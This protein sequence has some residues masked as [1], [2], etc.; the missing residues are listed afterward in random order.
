MQGFSSKV[1]KSIP[2]YSNK[3]LLNNF[4]HFKTIKSEF[5]Y[6]LTRGVGIVVIENLINYDVVKST[7]QEIYKII[8]NQKETNN[9][10][11]SNNQR[12]W[13]FYEKFCISNTNLFI[14]YFKN[15]IIDLI[16]SSYLGPKYEITNQINIVNPGS[17]AQVFHR[18]YHLGLMD[19]KMLEEYPMNVHISSPNLTLQGLVAHSKIN[20]KN[21]STKFIPYSHLKKNGF[22]LIK[23]NKVLD[24]CENNYIQL[25]LNIGDGVF[26]NPAIF[27][28]AGDNNDNNDRIAN[29]FQI[30]SAFSKP[31]ELVNNLLVKNLVEDKLNSMKLSD[32]ELKTLKNI[33]FNKY[34]YP[35]NLD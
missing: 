31:M 24:I 9:D 18:D 3:S 28:A 13:N 22:N 20:P 30:N 35:T 6:H 1:I 19:K 27:H 32:I 5:N 15:P 11:F 29:L 34:E 10:H 12:I 4:N 16:S 23:K 2:I 17:K 21:G 33:I 14:N 26:F 8:E 7:N 25:E